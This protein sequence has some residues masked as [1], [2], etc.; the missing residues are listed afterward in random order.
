MK[1]LARPTC[2]QVSILDSSYPLNLELVLAMSRIRFSIPSQLLHLPQRGGEIEKE[3]HE[4]EEE[5]GR[6]EHRTQNTEQRTQRARGGG[7]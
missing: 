7:G 6:T 1:K 5:G 2:T 3:V 4:R